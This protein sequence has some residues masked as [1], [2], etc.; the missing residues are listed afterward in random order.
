VELVVEL[1]VLVK[2]LVNQGAQVVE[3]MLA[4]RAVQLLNLVRHIRVV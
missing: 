1:L 4:V 3:V 2:L